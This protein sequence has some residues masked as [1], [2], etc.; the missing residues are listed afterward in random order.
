M[1]A[2]QWEDPK[3]TA[4][5]SRHSQKTEVMEELKKNPGRWARVSDHPTSAT[6]KTIRRRL[7][8]QF[9]EHEFRCETQEGKG[10]VFGR[11][12]EIVPNPADVI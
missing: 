12:P 4:P 7:V 9:P 5:S 2:I 3:F 6:A 11:Y 1:T 8:R 10:V